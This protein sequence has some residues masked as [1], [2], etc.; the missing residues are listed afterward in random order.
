MD[1]AQIQ[2]LYQQY[3]Y[4][5]IAAGF[6]IG[7]V[8]G[9]I[10]LILGIRRKKRNLGLAGFALSGIAG[11][12][13][14][15]IAVIVS[16]VFVWLILASKLARTITGAIITLTG[17]FLAAFG[18]IRMNSFASQVADVVGTGDQ[19]AFL[20]I[21]G[22]FLLSILGL[23]LSIISVWPSSNSNLPT[24]ASSS[25]PEQGSLKDNFS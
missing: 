24:S 10:P 20:F 4:Y 12:F 19:L 6:V 9:S 17:I 8:F 1:Q 7:L 13:S 15:L 16:V 11:A 25:S 5:I 22:G 23:I 14:P 3:F 21:F 18:F 2:Q